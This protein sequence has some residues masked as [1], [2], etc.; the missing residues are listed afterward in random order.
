MAS[1]TRPL[2]AATPEPLAAPGVAR[3]LG[4]DPAAAGATGFAVVETDGR[5]CR[6][7]HYGAVKPKRN[8]TPSARLEGIHTLVA[9]LLA[10]FSPSAVAVES[11][12]AAI[13]IRSA[14]LLAEVRGVVL[15]AAAQQ[16][17]PV[18][19]YSPR[20]IKANVAGYGQASK[21]QVQVMVRSQLHLDELPQPHDAA[22]A[23]AVALCH[24]HSQ[25]SRARVTRALSAGAAS[26][27]A[28]RAQRISGFRGRVP[29]PRGA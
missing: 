27:N 5:A 2:R 11:P 14:L 25:R 8:A 4:L 29:P 20:E 28:G 9:K 6:V 7:L 16:Q 12:F 17:V 24:I 1:I 19:S 15:L 26:G 13:N 3:I 23:L 21:E 10:D 22:D 18:E